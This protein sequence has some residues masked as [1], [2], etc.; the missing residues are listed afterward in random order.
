MIEANP[1]VRFRPA[2]LGAPVAVEAVDDYRREPIIALCERSRQ[3]HSQAI[4]D[5]PLPT[6]ASED[7]ERIERIVAR[8]AEDEGQ[9]IGRSIRS[10]D[11]R[12]ASSAHQ[13]GR[14]GQPVSRPGVPANPV[15]SSRGTA[16]GSALPSG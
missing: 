8:A 13:S 16:F 11:G 1:A 12:S 15:G 5:L 14:C 9:P 2:A 4:L 10:R 6:P 7:A 3:R